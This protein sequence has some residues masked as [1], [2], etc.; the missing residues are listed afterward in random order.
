MLVLLPPSEAKSPGGDGPPLGERPAL[1]TPGLAETRA[2]LMAAIRTAAG[3]RPSALVTGLKLPAGLAAEALAA[4]RG[5]AGAP[6]KPA[7]D[8]YAG[9]VFAALDVASLTAAAR[10]RAEE[11]V[12]VFSA[13]WGVV[14]G[15]DLVPDYRVPAS[16][17]VPGLGGVTTHWRG[18]LAA[19]LPGL[20]ADDP[21]LDLRSGDYA[22]MWRPDDDLRRQVVVV[23]VLAERGTGAARKVGP[24]SYHAKWVKGLLARH[25]LS[26]RRRPRTAR[27]L[28]AAVAAAAA[29]L[30][31]RVED[32]G[33]RAAPALDLVGRY[34]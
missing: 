33:T 34:P 22:A 2:T 18:P 28:V 29:D 15:S 7:L 12:L 32:R 8:R 26:G 14:R 5:A 6:T 20:V 3:R 30:D 16:G 25:L 4:D 10:R 11:Q 1:S 17:T 24:V 23:R 13:L 27:D 21:V 19:A 9:V 31:L